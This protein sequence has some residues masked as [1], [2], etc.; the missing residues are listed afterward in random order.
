MFEGR[1]GLPEVGYHRLV[2]VSLV[3][4]NLEKDVGAS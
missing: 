1:L 4:V 3:G 2:D